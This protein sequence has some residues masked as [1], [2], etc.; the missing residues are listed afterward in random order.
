MKS[1]AWCVCADDD[2]SFTSAA[3]SDTLVFTLLAD[4]V[5]EGV[6]SAGRGFEDATSR[7]ASCAAYWC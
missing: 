3:G 4:A 7:A 6:P 2:L 5:P 1:S